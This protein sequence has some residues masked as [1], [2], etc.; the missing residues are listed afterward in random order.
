MITLVDRDRQ[1]F[2]SSVGLKLEE[3]PRESSFCAHTVFDRATMVV[4]DAL[5][6]D[7]FAENPL[8]VGEPRIRFY[9][10]APLILS[11]GSCVGT[12]CLLDTRPHRFA[13]ADIRLLEELRDL[14]VSELERE[15]AASLAGG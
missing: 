14:A 12:L 11:N 1:W 15:P 4:S 7:R 5:F 8:V 2:M 10:G 9:A 6:D 3:T 13:A